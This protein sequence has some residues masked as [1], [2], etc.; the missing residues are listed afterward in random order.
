[1]VLKME[2]M[3]CAFLNK[4]LGRELGSIDNKALEQIVAKVSTA[5]CL[6]QL[7]FIAT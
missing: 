7:L 2:Y 4:G 5:P 6:I 3:L 1:M